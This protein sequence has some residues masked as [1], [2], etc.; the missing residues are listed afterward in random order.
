ML[1]HLDIIEVHA[2]AHAWSNYIY[3]PTISYC[4]HMSTGC[5]DFDFSRIGESVKHYMHA[6]FV[7]TVMD[8]KKNISINPQNIVNHYQLAETFSLLY[9]TQWCMLVLYHPFFPYCKVVS[10]HATIGISLLVMP[11]SL[12]VLPEAHFVHVKGE[13]NWTLFLSF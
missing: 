5:L 12:T 8:R 9:F 11:T 1:S 13:A 7:K 4:M 10:I 6:D 3:Q 2:P